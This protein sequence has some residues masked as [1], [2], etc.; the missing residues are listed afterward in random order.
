M[1]NELTSTSTR[2]IS[3]H[4]YCK[5]NIPC[6]IVSFATF[7]SYSGGKFNQIIL[8]Y[9]QMHDQKTNQLPFHSVIYKERHP[10]NN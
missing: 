10:T 2:R 1:S 9:I 3:R 7:I 5:T 8:E 4:H 6:V